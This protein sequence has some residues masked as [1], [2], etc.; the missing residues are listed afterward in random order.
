MSVRGKVLDL[1]DTASAD[2]VEPLYSIEVA[3]TKSPKRGMKCGAIVV[4]RQSTHLDLAESLDKVEK[5]SDQ[6]LLAEQ[7]KNGTDYMFKDPEYFTEEKGQWI[8]FAA[9]RLLEL[10]DQLGG[11]ARVTI[12]CPALRVKQRVSRESIVRHRSNPRSLFSTLWD[13]DKLLSRDYH[14]DPWLKVIRRGRIGAD[15]V[16]KG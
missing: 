2:A 15:V 1:L 9:G 5:M 3:L 7:A 4:F 8:A 6:E 13:I 10:F 11:N 16:K 14:Y 12:K